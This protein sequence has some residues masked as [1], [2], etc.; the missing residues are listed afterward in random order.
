MLVQRRRRWVNIGQTLV[1]CLLCSALFITPFSAGN[2]FKRQNLTPKD[3]T[4]TER[5]KYL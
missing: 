3:G 2:D 4:G 1:S 5:V